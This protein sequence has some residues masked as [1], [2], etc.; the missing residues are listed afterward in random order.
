M[1]TGRSLN[2]ALPFIEELNI[3]VPV[4]LYNGAKLYDPIQKVFLK[5]HALPVSSFRHALYN[6]ELTGE[7]L[8]LNVLVFCQE[9]I[10]CPSITNTVE[11]YMQ[12]DKV[13]IIET[14]MSDL[15]DLFQS[16]TKI[17][18]L[19]D[20]D[21][22]KSFQ[23]KCFSR[24]EQPVAPLWHAVQSEPELLE[25]LPPNVNKGSACLELIEV[26]GL[27]MA[28]LTAVGDNLNDIEM[29]ALIPNGVAVQNAHPILKETADWVTSR[30]ND[31]DAIIE[32]FDQKAVAI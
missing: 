11:R 17:M 3:K 22:L 14:S 30:S 18:F 24:T 1:A 15:Y 25:I 31:E 8:G 12:K 28:D 21:A 29:I 13:N 9:Q 7:G 6:Y 32:V 16:S 20:P 4:I 2:S 19:G 10:Y 5:E 23:E 27:D 26:L